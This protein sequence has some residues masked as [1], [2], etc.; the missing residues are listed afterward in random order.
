M[1]KKKFLYLCSVEI[2]VLSSDRKNI[3]L[4]K[5][6]D[7]KA[8]LPG[9]YAGLGGKMDSASLENPLEAAFREVKEESGLRK[10]DFSKTDFKAMF[11]VSDKFGRWA[12]YEFVFILKDRKKNF[13]DREMEEGILRWVGIKELPHL[14][15]I[16]D[17]KKGVLEKIIFHK[18]FL[19]IKSRYDRKNRLTGLSVQET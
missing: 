3:L 1:D 12:V 7:N 2:F 16:P 13:P 10:K 6:A 4:L 15:L 18:G 11:T 17:L 19:W 8:V 9:Y 14:N 5:R